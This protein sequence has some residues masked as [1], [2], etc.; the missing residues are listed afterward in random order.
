VRGVE[1]DHVTA[2]RW[3]QAVT[4]EFIDAAPRSRRA[5]EDRSVVRSRLRGVAI[6][7]MSVSRYRDRHSASGAK[8]DAGDAHVL[9]EVVRLDRGHHRPI[10]PDS[11]LSQAMKLVARSHQTLIWG[12]ARHGLRLRG[13]LREYIPAALTDFEDL[14]SSEA[15]ELLSA[16]PDPA[17]GATVEG[18]DLG[19]ARARPAAQ[20]RRMHRSPLQQAESH[21]AP[22]ALR[23]SSL[24]SR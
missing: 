23:E 17:R 15:V 19:C 1:V 9:V 2:C 4:S 3:V 20:R 6:N 21:S 5:K 24:R 7:P 8:S 11:T 16:A 18:E 14:D 22:A 10:A 12:R 13:T